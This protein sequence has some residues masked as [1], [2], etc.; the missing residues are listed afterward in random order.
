MTL[1]VNIPLSNEMYERV[2]KLAQ[3]HDKEVPQF[4]AEHLAETL[5][6]TL[7]EDSYD[8]NTAVERE[9]D[10][11]H[12]LHATLW[13]KYRGQYVA[14]YRGELIDHDSDQLALVNRLDEAYPNQFVLVRQ[15]TADP[16][17]EY[18]RIAIR[19]AD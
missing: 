11:Y 17:P 8:K 14:I 16:E 10:V 18:R 5:A 15:V 3:Q 12:A 4:L 6:E 1:H 9:R 2:Q 13:S 7:V 19:W